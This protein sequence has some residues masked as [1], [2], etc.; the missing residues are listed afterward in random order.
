E[1]ENDFVNNAANTLLGDVD[2]EVSVRRSLVRVIDTGETLDLTS[3]SLGVDTALLGL[4]T[5]LERGVDVDEEERAT[6]LGDGVTGGLARVLVGGNGGGDIGGTGAGQLTSD[7]GDTLDVL[8]AVLAGEAELGGE[9][10]ADG[11]TKEQ[12]DG[13]T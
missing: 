4:L 12:G 13:V 11:V 1:H 5:V 8:V 3:A 2:G 7:E 10:V 9:R 6:Q